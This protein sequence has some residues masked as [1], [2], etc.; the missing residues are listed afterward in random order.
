MYMLPSVFV[1]LEALPLNANGKLNR[2]ALPAPDHSRPQLE[3]A[4][5][6]AQTPVEQRLAA[7]W[8]EFLR[9]E[10][11]G[12]HDNFFELGGDSILSIQVVA[13]ANQENM[14]LTPSQLF[15]YQTIAELAAVVDIVKTPEAEQGLVTGPVPLTP[16]QHWYFEQHQIDPH[17]CNQAVLLEVKEKLDPVLL[18]QT[19]Q[20]LVSH[21]DALRLRFVCEQTG[22]RQFNA[23]A[24]QRV[25]VLHLDL[26]SATEPE[27]MATV[28]AVAN[29]QQASFDLTQG[30][31]M[32][33]VLF[34]LGAEQPAVLLVIF[35]HL[36]IDGVSWRILFQDLATIYEQLERGEPVVLAPKTTSFKQWTESLTAYAQS[37]SIKQES[38]FWEAGSR[39]AVKPLPLDHPEGSNDEAAAHPVVVSLTSEETRALLKEVPGIYHTQINDVLLAALAQGLAQWTGETAFLVELEGHGREEIIQGLDLSRT[40]GWFTSVYPVLLELTE[41]GDSVA[42]LKSIK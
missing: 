5:V 35:H 25:H 21:H 37:E 39:P 22:W 7:I 28:E 17:H 19:V 34:D 36:A 10:R 24:D 20:Y 15:E 40:V 38:A 14:H 4:M 8:C 27:Q 18:E 41:T 31:L 9:I 26:S 11:V 32:R 1:F 29:Q 12:I 16:I 33:V 6:F 23:G 13:R 30:P 2:K 3:E 42:T